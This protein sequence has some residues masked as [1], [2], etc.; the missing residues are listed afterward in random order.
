MKQKVTVIVQKQ[1][2]GNS[3]NPGN[4]VHSGIGTYTE[5]LLSSMKE[6][7]DFKIK[8]PQYFLQYPVCLKKQEGIMHITSQDLALPLLFRK[9][10]RTVVTVHDIIP[11]QYPLFENA[12]HIRRKKCDKWIYGKTIEALQYAD[13]I[14]CVSNATKNALIKYMPKLEPKITV[15]HEDR[16]STRLNSSH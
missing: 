16:K 5:L 4:R 3:M 2:N 10:A 14:I 9:Y 6:V 13:Q 12:L 8:S 1:N 11:L 7:C 15:V